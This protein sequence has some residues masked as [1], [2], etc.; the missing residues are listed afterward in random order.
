MIATW[1]A[2]LTAAVLLGGAGIGALIARAAD[3]PAGAGAVL[4]LVVAFLVTGFL[5]RRSF[6]EP[7]R[8]G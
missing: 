1:L 3:V 5:L 4:G 7:P 6:D 8:E 2:L